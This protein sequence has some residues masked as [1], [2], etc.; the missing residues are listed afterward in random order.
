MGP[1]GFPE[2]TNLRCSA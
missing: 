2:S 1:I